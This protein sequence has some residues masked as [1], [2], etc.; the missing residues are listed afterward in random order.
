MRTLLSLGGL[1]V[2]PLHYHRIVFVVADKNAFLVASDYVTR[3]SLSVF[4][5]RKI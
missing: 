2:R 3:L 1:Y 5:A 4:L